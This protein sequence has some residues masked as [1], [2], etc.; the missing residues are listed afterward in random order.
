M[1]AR[2]LQQEVDKTFK[3]VAEGIAHFESVYEKLQQCTNASQKD[4]L[5]DMLKREIKKLQRHR[6]QIKTWAANSEIKDKKPLLDQ[7]KLIETVRIRC[8]CISFSTHAFRGA[9]FTSCFR[10]RALLWVQAFSYYL[11]LRDSE[12]FSPCRLRHTVPPIPTY[13]FFLYQHAD[14]SAFILGLCHIAN[15]KVQSRGKGNENE[16]V[17]KRRVIGIDAT[18]SKV[19]TETRYAQFPIGSYR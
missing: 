1:A 14:Y 7:R 19:A 5:E 18:G 6:D 16:S 12:V 4:K 3:R 2:K 11:V 17:F 15:G 9:S 8:C 10:F 13:Y